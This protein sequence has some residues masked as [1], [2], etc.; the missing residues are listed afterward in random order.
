[1]TNNEKLFN[2]PFSK[3][4][5]LYV[6]KVERK[7]QD[8]AKINELLFWLYGYESDSIDQLVNS[9]IT[10]EAFI[11]QAPNKNE[12]RHLIKGVIC[13]VRI[14]EIK[15]PMYQEIRYLDKIIDELAKGRDINK[16]KRKKD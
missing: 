2:M 10:L 1:M 14:E 8:K 16:I 15:D 3:I 11:S 6:K 7:N 4:Y 12:S 5:D 9:D 13:G